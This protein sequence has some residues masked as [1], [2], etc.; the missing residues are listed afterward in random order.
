[1]AR[2]L[3]KYVSP[4]I[5]A[6]LGAFY[7]A[8]ADKYFLRL[9][10]NLTEVG[11]YALAARV[12]SV[13][14]VLNNAFNMSWMADR[15]EIVKQ[16]NA[17]EVYRRVFRFF[18]SFLILVGAALALFTNDLFMVLTSPSFYS[19]ADVV[20]IIIASVIIHSTT[21]YCN[22]GI[23]LHKRTA[24]LAR[25]SFYKVILSTIGYVV[26]IPHFGLFGAAITVLAVNIFEL[27]WVNIKS[28]KL[29]DM[30]LQWGAAGLMSVF[31]VVCVVIGM[32]LPNADVVSF[33]ARIALYVSLLVVIFHMP[34]WTIEDKKIIS[35]GFNNIKKRLST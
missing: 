19:A 21:V 5:L 2:E 34:F 31:A 27:T 29:Y 18:T 17:K 3:I 33:T 30:Q 11:L 16:E 25:V 10:G 7:V 20:P 32:L 26:L 1:M 22:F 9:F 23:M 15:F 13:L 12:G 24:Y 4:L 28:T 6:S 8:Y 14:G 35:Y